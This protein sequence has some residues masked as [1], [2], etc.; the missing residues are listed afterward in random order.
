MGSVQERKVCTAKFWKE[1]YSNKQTHPINLVSRNFADEKLT[2]NC[3]LRDFRKYDIAGDS[4][5]VLTLTFRTT[6]HPRMYMRWAKVRVT[7]GEPTSAVILTHCE[8]SKVKGLN[9]ERQV[10]TN[11]GVE[12]KV[13]APGAGAEVGHAGRTTTQTKNKTWQFETSRVFSGREDGHYQ[14]M[15]LSLKVPDDSCCE[16]FSDRPIVVAALIKDHGEHAI[17]VSSAIVEGKAK[18]WIDISRCWANLF[19]AKIQWQAR[20][21]PLTKGRPSKQ[22]SSIDALQHHLGLEMI[23]CN[24][25]EAPIG[26]DILFVWHIDPLLTTFQPDL[27]IDERSIIPSRR[28]IQMTKGRRHVQ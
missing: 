21:I 6:Q 7:F 13:Q 4:A 24:A 26:T 28:T 5:L 25:R 1:E 23:S 11:F 16:S 10:E 18:H 19:P 22:W 17:A 2:V 14:I 9:Q 3:D 20:S 8:P 15:G 27:T 12:P